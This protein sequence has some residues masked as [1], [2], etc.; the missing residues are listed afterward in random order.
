MKMYFELETGGNELLGL[1]VIHSSHTADIHVLELGNS[2]MELMKVI[3]PNLQYRILEALGERTTPGL[4]KWFFYHADGI[5]TWY[6]EGKHYPVRAMDE[7]LLV[8]QFVKQMEA[9]CCQWY[10]EGRVK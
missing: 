2:N 6:D 3:S 8:P 4:W 9:R 10:G 7:Q 1:E 5:I